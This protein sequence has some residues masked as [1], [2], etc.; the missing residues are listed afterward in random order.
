ML[1][2][3]S[4][5][6]SGILGVG[7]GIHRGIGNGMRSSDRQSW[8]IGEWLVDVVREWEAIGVRIFGGL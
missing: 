3:G 2:E 6:D 5:A 8:L 4:G 7:V 1:L